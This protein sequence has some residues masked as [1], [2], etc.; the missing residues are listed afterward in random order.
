M[1][2]RPDRKIYRSRD[3]KVVTG[4]SGGIA[5]AYDLDPSMVRILVLLVV[6]FTFPIGLIA[7]LA[8][9]LVVPSKEDK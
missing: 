4:L 7:Y 9:S 1:T 2:E 3:D 6:I 5:E 8:T